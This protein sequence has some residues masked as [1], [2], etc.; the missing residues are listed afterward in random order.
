MMIRLVKAAGDTDQTR[1]ELVW[2]GFTPT[3]ATTSVI[4][5][6]FYFFIEL[7][8]DVSVSVDGSYNT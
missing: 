1:P 7:F 4:I 8:L 2:T 5:F 6:T 3:D